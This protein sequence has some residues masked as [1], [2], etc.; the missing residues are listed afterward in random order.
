MSLLE[1]GGGGGVRAQV[2]F[3]SRER[4]LATCIPLEGLFQ[5]L[6]ERL[7]FVAGL[8]HEAA[9]RSYSPYQALNVFNV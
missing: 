4:L 8:R 3:E 6:K 7:T 1:P 2:G 9:Q 5:N